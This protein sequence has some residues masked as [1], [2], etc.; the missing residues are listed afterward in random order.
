MVDEVL[1]YLCTPAGLVEMR[2]AKEEKDLCE[3]MYTFWSTQKCHD[4]VS[5]VYELVMKSNQKELNE[6]RKLRHESDLRAWKPYLSGKNT[7]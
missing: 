1:H 4:P 3:E 5:E 2:T 7:W 6:E